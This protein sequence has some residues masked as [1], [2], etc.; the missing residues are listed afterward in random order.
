[1]L[2]RRSRNKRK[3]K[4]RRV[5]RDFLHPGKEEEKGVNKYRKC[6]FSNGRVVGNGGPH[7]PHDLENA[8]LTVVT[9]IVLYREE[10]GKRPS[11]WCRAGKRASQK[12]YFFL[13]RRV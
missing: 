6:W 1:L 12:T 4:I 7:S 10:R 8:P 5:W 13:K 2:K 11:P 3:K 9:K